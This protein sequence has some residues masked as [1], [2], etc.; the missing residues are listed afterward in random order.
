MTRSSPALTAWNAGEFGPTLEGRIDFVK[1]PLAAKRLE[2]FVPLPQGPLERRGGSR[3]VAEVKD[4]SKRVW[5]RRFEFSTTQAYILEFGDKYI[6][7]Y[8]NHGQVLVSQSWSN[9]TQYQIG[10]AV[11]APNL[12][13]YIAIAPSFNV[14]P[15]N[16]N[17]WKQLSGLIYEIETPYDVADLTNDE[18][19]F[20]LQIEQ[21]ADV[22]YIAGNG[23]YPP[24]TLTRYASTRWVLEE[25]K[26]D[27]GPWLDEN[28]DQTI[29]MWASASTGTI[30]IRSNVDVFAST[31]VGRLI[32]LRLQNFDTPPWEPDTTS[33]ITAGEQRRYDGK[34]YRALNSAQ[35]GVSPPIHDVGIASDGSVYWEFQD[36][37]YGVARIATVVSPTE[38]TATV[39]KQMPAGVVGVARTISGITNA[40]PAEVT[41]ASHGFVAGNSVYI[42]GVVGMTEINHRFYQV[43]SPATNTFD[44]A[45]TDSSGYGVYA[46]GGTAVKHA[47]SRWSLGAWSDTSGWPSA[48]AFGYDRL[49]WAHDLSIWS[50]V[51]GDYTDFSLDASGVVTP[52]SAVTVRL[53]AQDVNKILWMVEAERLIIG[54]PG[55]EFA[56]GPITTVDPLGPENVQIKPQSK[57]RCRSVPPLI[58]DTALLYV[59]RSGRRMLLMDYDFT[60][61]RYRSA[62]MNALN[63]HITKSGIVDWAHQ[64]EPHSV[65]WCVLANGS[66]VA[67]TLDQEQDVTGWHRHPIGGNGIVESVEC[68]PDPLG[69]RDEVWIVVRRTIDGETKRYVEY[70]ERPYEDGDDQADAFY[71][72]SGLTYSGSPVT[73]ISGLDH[74]EGET[75]QVLADGAAHPDRT[76]AGGQITLAAAASKVHVGLAAPAKLVTMRLEA[77]A[78]DGTSQGKVKR[79]NS[80]VIRLL[81]TLGGK[82]GL[83]GRRLTEIKYRTPSMPMDEAP[84]LFT[85]DKQQSFDGDYEPDCRIEVQ[86]T[87]PFPMTIVGLYPSVRTYD[88]RK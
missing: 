14:Q 45:V 29:V 34:N 4:S 49:W 46:S 20:A 28:K 5:L 6:R 86:Q 82:I 81:N 10:D 7:F 78:P 2:N 84:A 59:Q 61:E 21:S 87:Q 64:A 43:A 77:G 62:N 13:A 66:L 11:T 44:L 68:I 18:G 74:L 76:V 53:S 54:T 63:A 79:V 65:I 83:E 40:S 15:P 36:A 55:G 16:G 26:P 3:F 41:A 58:V 47:T 50:S 37:G 31:D 85:G 42:Y 51:V 38:V 22:L 25:Y 35:T 56:L 32:R 69:D 19:V 71:V 8:T 17:Y 39:I 27:T 30:T 75:V 67:F 52:D 33:S 88:Q 73:T 60:R 12:F 1:Y 72:D 57:K 70:L 80:L 9:S 24:Y 48:V 23:Q